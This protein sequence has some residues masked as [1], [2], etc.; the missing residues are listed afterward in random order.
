[1]S[2]FLTIS[3]AAAAVEAG[4]VTSVEL[5]Q[6]ALD[7][8]DAHDPTLGVFIS[9]F[10][11]SALQAARAADA[12]RS[13]GRV[14]GPLHGIPLGIKDIITT[15][16]GPSTAQSTVSRIIYGGRPVVTGF[17]RFASGPIR[18]EVD[19]HRS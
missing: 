8:A 3:D 17:I 9:R 12:E 10:P 13:Q 6:A 4:T 19:L 11:E 18:L 16:E 2:D 5:V 7:A 15:V 14:R 1:M